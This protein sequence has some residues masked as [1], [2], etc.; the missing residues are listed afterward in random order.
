MNDKLKSKEVEQLFEAILSLNDVKECYDFFEDVCTIN[1]LLSL[2]QKAKPSHTQN[3]QFLSPSWVFDKWDISSNYAI[4]NCK[5]HHSKNNDTDD[6]HDPGQAI[7]KL[8]RQSF[9]FL[10]FHRRTLHLIGCVFNLR[11]DICIFFTVF[12][13]YAAAGILPFR[14]IYLYDFCTSIFNCL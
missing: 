7:C 13:I 8:I 11:N 4:G 6:Y 12:I 10:I 14:H 3:R 5:N 2:A 1:E 9:F